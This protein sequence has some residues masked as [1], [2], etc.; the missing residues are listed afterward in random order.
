MLMEVQTAI[1][2][3][4]EGLDDTFFAELYSSPDRI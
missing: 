4:M 1:K 2:T 3:G